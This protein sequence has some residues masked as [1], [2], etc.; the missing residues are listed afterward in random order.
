MSAY[1]DEDE[2]SASLYVSRTP[3]AM[4]SSRSRGPFLTMLNP[5]GRSYAGYTH[6]GVVEEEDEEEIDLVPPHGNRAQ[7]SR[8]DSMDDDEVPASLMIETSKPKQLPYEVNQPPRPSDLIQPSLPQPAVAPPRPMRG[9]DDYERALWNWF[10]VYN[11][12]AFLQEVYAYYEGKGIYCIALSKGLNLLTVGFVIGFSTFLLGC[13]DYSKIRHTGTTQLADVIIP[14]CVSR[15]SGFTW[16][17]F[18]LFGAFYLYQILQFIVSIRRLLELYQ[19]YTHL[20]GV[21]DSDVQTISWPEIVRRIGLIREH[22][23]ITS[24]SS[25]TDGANPTT[26]K[27]DAHDIA[28]RIMRQ[29]N[30]LIALFDRKLVDL[31]VPLPGFLERFFPPKEQR[32]NLTRALEWNLR[33]CL[34]GHLFDHR[35]TVKGV[36]LKE[37]NKHGL[38]A[39]LRRRMIFFG[40]INFLFVP[41]IVVYLLMHSFFRY[42]EEYH[43]N[44]SSIGS[45]QYT[46]FAKWTFRE[47]NELPHI[48]ARRLDNSYPMANEYIDQFP[49]EKVTIIARF[50]SFVSGS[51][52]AVLILASVIDPDIFLHFEITPGRTVVF[53][54]TVFGGIVGFARGMVP[55]AHRVFDPEMLLKEVIEYT[56]YLPKEWD[57]QLH[58]KRVHTEFGLLFDMKVTIFLNELISVIV[59]PFILCY[60]LPPCAEKIIDFFRESTW[61]VEGLGY[62]CNSAV[63]DLGRHGRPHGHGAEEA[64]PSNVVE[65]DKPREKE[66]KMEQS[67]LNFK[68]ANPEWNPSDQ[69]GSLYLSRNADLAH[70]PRAG[71]SLRQARSR[72]RFGQHLHPTS[73]VQPRLTSPT[74]V[75]RDRP[76]TSD[77]FGAEVQMP[78]SK[79][80]D[81]AAMYERALQNSV[82]LRSSTAPAPRRAS[83]PTPE[84]MTKDSSTRNMDVGSALG[85]SYDD[86]QPIFGEP[87]RRADEPIDE[88]FVDG[89]IMGLL[90]NIYEQRKGVL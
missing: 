57:G 40:A 69:T 65:V 66:T 48:F 3:N 67:L 38:A 29:E 89:G 16:L 46:P 70:P 47:Y 61:H 72:S 35:G 4:G 79:L 74:I 81:R 42:F 2:P 52:A 76:G 12:D 1:V 22:N 31:R 50:V 15:F 26:A 37:K 23:P 30:Y 39:E 25:Q 11:L 21:P 27:L 63:F 82:K 60:S 24:L 80:A 20:L 54:I 5:M 78:E 64:G 32:Q 73:Q 44:P 17:F 53:Y 62:V 9:L 84:P 18:V 68:A 6:P 85:E 75:H 41:F 87:Q 83:E 58:S 71:P 56:H 86:A 88:E 34:L 14:R 59:T 13:V 10:N 19:F 90:G 7:P 49:K 36:F 77:N 55:D 28:N 43:K 33:A 45:R 51:F 8:Q